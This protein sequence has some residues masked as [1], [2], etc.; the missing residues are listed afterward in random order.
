MLLEKKIKE[1]ILFNKDNRT[2]LYD[3]DFEAA[4]KQK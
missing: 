1:S 4:W 2:I 3:V